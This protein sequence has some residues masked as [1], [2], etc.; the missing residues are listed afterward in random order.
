[1]SSLWNSVVKHQDLADIS[2]YQ[3]NR[4]TGRQMSSLSLESLGYAQDWYVPT[5]IPKPSSAFPP[6]S[7]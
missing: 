5:N 1:M 4:Q 7:L 6:S 3:L 2:N